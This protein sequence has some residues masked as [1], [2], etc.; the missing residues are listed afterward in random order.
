MVWKLWQM[1]RWIGFE[2]MVLRLRTKGNDWELIK[3]IVEVGYAYWNKESDIK[4]D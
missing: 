2:S 3:I 4:I 1:C